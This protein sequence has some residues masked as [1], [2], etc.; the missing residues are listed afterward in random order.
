M[1]YDKQ[2]LSELELTSSH[3][4]NHRHLVAKSGELPSGKILKRTYVVLGEKPVFENHGCYW[5]RNLQFTLTTVFIG[6]NYYQNY[7]KPN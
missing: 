7:V 2:R 4:F 5:L 6:R 3:S 1:Y